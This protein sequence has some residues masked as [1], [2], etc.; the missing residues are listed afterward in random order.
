MNSKLKEDVGIIHNLNQ[1]MDDDCA[2]TLELSLFTS[3]IKKEIC[4]V[5]DSFLSF[6]R[7]FEEKKAHNMF[8]L[9]LNPRFKSLHLLVVS[10]AFLL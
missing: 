3:N 8:S 1:F 7:N 6:L 4:G 2:I 9:M 5:L 10:K